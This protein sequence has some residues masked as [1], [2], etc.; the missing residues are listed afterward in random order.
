MNVFRSK[1]SHKT[2]DS[3][4]SYDE[5]RSQSL[6]ID[7]ASGMDKWKYEEESDIYDYREI[8]LKLNKL[9]KYRKTGDDVGLLFA[10]NEGIHGNM[11]GMGNPALYNMALSGT[12]QLIV[13]YIDEIVDALNHI[14]SVDETIIS[15]EE[16][17]DF[18]RRASHCFGR[19]ALMLSGG[20]QLGNFHVGVLKAMITNNILPNVISGSSAGSVFAALVGT[21][22][23]AEL[24]EFFDSK[25]LLIEVRRETKLY[26]KIFRRRESID[27]E[28]LKETIN[29]LI[30]DITF[31]EA[32]ERTGRNI[33]I[34]VAPYDAHQK[35]R[36]LNA[37]AS[38]NVLIRSAVLA[39]CAIPGIFP[40][41]T[42]MAKD[43]DG[44]SVAYLP[45]RKWVDGSM[46]NDLPS[47]RLT[48]LYGVNHFIVSLT[49]PFI[50]PFVDDP[51][52]KTDLFVATKMFTKSMIKG[53]AQLNYTLASKFFKYWPSMAL[54]ANNINS[55]IQQDYTG[56]INIVADFKVVKPG[57]LLSVMS[58][59]E[60]SE[61]IF[62][63][64]KA[65][66]P[67]VE[68]IRVTTKIGRVLDDIY[69]KY[70]NI[71]LGVLS[72]VS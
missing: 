71:D 32:K 4:K 13:D 60:L 72:V 17:V 29:R 22:S 45:S 57:R 68:A 42:L 54:L 7:K 15:V 53:S 3:A 37:I 20:G 46:S 47:K 6:K 40:P 50:L 39:S 55:V 44:N 19:S 24:L 14:V 16:K 1:E 8:K 28:K 12:K 66:W 21:Y 10:L 25:N 2:L 49:N 59:K 64:E 30:P 65:T 51:S 69:N 34:S 26:N 62:N 48:R 56:D 67:K 52:K 35:S 36:L 38:P 61:L 63:G 58:E 43:R 70:K 5:W 9:R 23:D 31:Q 41:V 33:N 27:I 11:A 18:F